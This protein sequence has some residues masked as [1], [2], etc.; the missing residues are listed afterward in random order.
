MLHEE[1]LSKDVLRP[2]F[3]SVD[4]GVLTR[5]VSEIKKK[6]DGARV[7]FILK[8]NAYGHGLLR[9][10]AHLEELGVAYI[11]VAY[12]EEGIMLRE[13]GIKTPILILGGIS[14]LQIPLFIKYDLTITASS[15]DKLEQIESTAKAMGKRARAH[16]K[17]DTG[18]ERIGMH[19]YSAKKL[20]LAA[21]RCIH[22]EIEG[23]FSHFARAD[24]ED[25]EYTRLQ[26]S[27]FEQVLDIYQELRIGLPECV[28]ISNSGGL[29]Q[30][31]FG[32][33]NMVRVGILLYGIYPSDHLRPK[34]DVRPALSWQTTVVFFKVVRKDFPVSYGG[35]WMPDEMTR[36]VTIPVGYGD[37]YMRAMS[38]KCKVIIRGTKY[39]AVGAICMDQT[40]INIGKGTA[41]NGDPVTLIG[42]QGDEQITVED[43]AEWAGTI[44]Y[45][46]MTN[47]NTRVPRVYVD[48]SVNPYIS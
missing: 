28:H 30:Y 7:M 17:I 39:P 29:L 41:Y 4:L 26:V 22:T 9:V 42:R 35:H 44:P 25:L 3:I 16:L 47:I 8:A 12:L 38:N 36:V 46:I 18:M 21:S 31:R 2:T 19:F 15:V 14:G 40:M 13:A 20:I 34:I 32:K 24:E 5:N 1:T 48:S 37:G 27:R 11:G 23:I 45:E 43:L 10:A 33:A 6:A